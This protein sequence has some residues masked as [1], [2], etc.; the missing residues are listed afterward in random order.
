MNVLGVQFGHDGSAAVARDGKLVAAIATERLTRRKKARG[1]TRD[2]LHYVIQKAGLQLEEIDLVTVCNWYWDPDNILLD[3][4]G[5]GFSLFSVDRSHE[6]SVEEYARAIDQ[7]QIFGAPLMMEIDGRAIPALVTNHEMAHAYYSY[8][9]SPHEQAV[10]VA[11]D[12]ADDASRNHAICYYQHG[13]DKA[14]FTEL[15]LSCGDEIGV[16]N[17]YSAMCDYLG[18]V[19]SLTDAGK[20]MAL[21][22]YGKP[23]ADWQQWVWRPLQKGAAVPE[24]F[25]AY[26]GILKSIGR[27]LPRAIYCQPPLPGEGGVIDPLWLNKQDWGTELSQTVAATAQKL[28]EESLM[29]LYEEISAVMRR[30]CRTITL[31]GGTMLNC[32][33]NGLL[34]NSGLFENVYV[35]PACGDDGLSI[36]GALYASNN[37][38]MK[39]RRLEAVDRR[40]PGHSVLEVFEGGRRYTE[41]EVSADVAS[42]ETQLSNAGVAVSSR[43]DDA[44]LCERVAS[45]IAE[46]RIVGWFYRGSELG[47]RALGHRSI[48]ADARDSRM[49]DTLNAKVKHREPFRPFAPVVL[50]E[51]AHEWFELPAGAASPFMLFSVKCLQPQRIPSGV[52]IDDTARVQTVDAA[53]N[54][55]FHQLVDAFH[56]KTGVPIIINTSFNVMG[57]PIVEAPQHA[58]DC[59]LG[60]N[61]DMLVLENRILEKP[62]RGNA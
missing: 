7:R 61:I 60:T 50:V 51:H 30:V 39:D 47:P 44:E 1:V 56:R 35:A 24:M 3:K 15:Q 40:K 19:P 26:I 31:S 46:G 53:N 57:E 38:T 29:R 2:T 41:S 21:A 42:R 33:C 18:F 48:L 8:A 34:L 58:I 4:K 6:V 36:G 25:R 55:R 62:S 27:P 49:K 11:V 52:H 37:L 5:E 10:S 12:A 9:V 28:L 22:A 23:L 13:D 14:L 59:F 16:G 43:I 32:V 45:A 20:V 17:F 54:G